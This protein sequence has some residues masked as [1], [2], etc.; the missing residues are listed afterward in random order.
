MNP[1]LPTRLG[2]ISTRKNI[3]GLP[4]VYTVVDEDVF[5]AASN[6]NKAFAIHNLKFTDGREEFRI[7]YYMIARRPRA[8]G[9]W[10]WGQYAPMMTKEDMALIFGR[11]KAKGWM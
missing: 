1:P 2:K 10:A 11:V 7:G 9:K 6:P 8:K 3:Q 5:I 4:M